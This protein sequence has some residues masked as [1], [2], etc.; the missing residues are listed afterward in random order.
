MYHDV[1]EYLAHIIIVDGQID[2]W[3]SQ[4]LD[5]FMQEAEATE[6]AYNRVKAVYA[7]DEDRRSLVQLIDSIGSQY[8]DKTRREI[9]AMG[10][11]IALVDDYLDPA[12]EYL[13]ELSLKT[14][15]ISIDEYEKL[16][17][18]IRAKLSTEKISVR[19]EE[20]EET[21]HPFFYSKIGSGMLKL[22]SRLVGRGTRERIQDFQTRLLL[23]GLEYTKAIEVCG[24]IAESD[25][26]YVQPI[27]EQ[28]EHALHT[29]LANVQDTVKNM[30]D[31]QDTELD[32]KGS[33]EAIQI[34]IQHKIQP[35]IIQQKQSLLKKKRAMHSFTI[36]FLGKTKAGKSTL[37][38][39][40]TG[41]GSEAVGKGKQRTTRFNRVYNWK[42][43]RIID[44]PGIGA[45]GGKSDEEI[46]ES[47]ID[48]SDVIC[49]VLKNDSIQESEF[50]FLG[51]IREKNKPFVILLNLKE[52]LMNE[53]RLNEFL[54]D[55]ERMYRR[56]DEKSIQGHIERIKR[57]A[58]QHYKKDMIE[59]IPVQLLAAQMSRM[60]PYQQHA[61]VLFKASHVGKFLN[62]LRL[63]IIGNG[64]IRR[65]QTILD[66]T[67]YTIE[68]SRM[69]VNEQLRDVS[70]IVN[71][72]KNNQ[73]K[74][75]QLLTRNYEKYA[76]AIQKH[77]SAQFAKLREQVPTFAGA[78]YNESQDTIEDAWAVKVRSI[79]FEKAI[80]S[81]LKSHVS[82]Y[83]EVI[84][85]Y[86]QEAIEDLEISEE[87][88]KAKGMNIQTSSTFSPRNIMKILSVGSLG[89][90]AFLISNPIGWIISGIGLL[91]GAIAGL[92]KSKETKIRE[93]TQKLESSLL[94]SIADQEKEV[95]SNA[96]QHFDKIHTKVSGLLATYFNEMV[97]LT[98]GIQNQIHVI[99]DDL[100]ASADR[101]NRAL[102][103][104][105]LNFAKQD[106][107]LPIEIDDALIDSTI[108]KVEREFGKSI[109]IY[110]Q[111]K[112]TEQRRHVISDIV[113][114]T[115]IFTPVSRK[116]DEGG[117]Q[118]DSA[119][120]NL[121][122]RSY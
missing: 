32:V 90:A 14:W 17:R 69:V 102:S 98:T 79:G 92:F 75:K 86:L 71:K 72:L 112:I 96:K 55:P 66:G 24:K 26:R 53:V 101:L 120:S 37:H 39:I 108:T 15:N 100:T 74:S 114:E 19:A 52:N 119:R 31:N 46:A 8:D 29:L 111:E 113:Q 51:T 104:R 103:W 109:I 43:I 82:S 33:M 121:P 22:A 67:F 89:V 117:K 54:Q 21:A 61:D 12:E 77:I 68:Q 35:L 94:S 76:D 44:T 85:K 11:M 106:R 70:F 88:L 50:K 5:L 57:Y 27:L 80:Q 73:T 97:Q 23:S 6:E 38:A 42:N 9:I 95:L 30:K 49:Y 18:D 78:Y 10:M 84:E 107:M 47:I 13:L 1:F 118:D 36:S 28:S 63:A 115:L 58:E 62:S 122:L 60:E 59:I 34:A 56:T 48:E 65:S 20:Q 7:D 41:Q 40:V 91:F 110:T 116:T 4:L 3:E 25:F 45:P 87:M 64:A 16:K 2:D 83:M 105:I 99:H 81:G 93:A